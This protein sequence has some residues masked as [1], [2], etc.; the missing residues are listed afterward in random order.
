MYI[1]YA[2]ERSDV[3]EPERANPSDA[4]M[5]VFYWTEEGSDVV[6]MPSCNQILSTGLRVEIPYGYM[7]EVKNRSSWAAKRGLLVGA[8]IIDSGYSGVIFIDL[9]NVGSK[10]QTIV[11][12]DK[13][14]QLVL[15]PIM[16][17]SLQKVQKEELY[18]EVSI[19]SKRGEGSLGSTD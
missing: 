18:K 17:P 16:Q 7:L 11:N 15:L 10:P 12:G 6:I 4:G 2:T 9:H 5:D 13:I 8:H 3:K 14:A 1:K 19:I